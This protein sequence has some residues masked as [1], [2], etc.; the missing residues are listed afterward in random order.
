[1][2]ISFEPDCPA[3]EIEVLA[4][5][6]AT[7]AN[8][9]SIMLCMDNAVLDSD[10]AATMVAEIV[11][12]QSRYPMFDGE[13]LRQIAGEYG[14]TSKT[15]DHSI[16]VVIDFGKSGPCHARMADAAGYFYGLTRVVSVEI[17]CLN[18]SFPRGR[19]SV[20]MAQNLVAVMV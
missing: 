6:I 1:M 12:S 7:I 18:V 10:K 16:F 19:K 2:I 20:T 17:G 13:L 9:E 4:S 15:C 5:N 8:Q 11:L 14:G 3:S